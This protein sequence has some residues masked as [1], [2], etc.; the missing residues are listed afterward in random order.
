M[1]FLIEF[2]EN[3]C[4]LNNF[5]IARETY[6]ICGNSFNANAV[7]HMILAQ[8]QRDTIIEPDSMGICED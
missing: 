5:D 1:R 6:K 3:E 8:V 4:K 2:A 7:A